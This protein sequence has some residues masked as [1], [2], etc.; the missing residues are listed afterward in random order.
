MQ[1]FDLFENKEPKKQS[2]VTALHDFLPLAIKHIGIT[3]IP[4]IN[5]EKEIDNNGQPTFGRFNSETGIISLAINQRHP[6]D[7]LRTLA[8]ELVHYGQNE[9]GEITSTSGE[10]GSDIENE[11]NAEA[12]VIM[13][14]FSKQYPQYIKLIPLTLP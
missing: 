1:L 14:L 10:T 3:Q 8:H 7:I 9:R 13:R 6:V 5:L 2:F 12:G 4:K 11:A